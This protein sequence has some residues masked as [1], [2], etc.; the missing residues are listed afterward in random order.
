MTIHAR[1]VLFAIAIGVILFIV[2]EVAS[3]IAW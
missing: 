2:A 3:G 1:H